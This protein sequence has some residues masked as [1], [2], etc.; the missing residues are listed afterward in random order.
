MESV[1]HASC[2]LGVRSI[3]GW[4]SM[5][6]GTFDTRFDRTR[7]EKLRTASFSR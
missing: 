3:T 2:A 1:R 6:E 5:T 4:R 7:D